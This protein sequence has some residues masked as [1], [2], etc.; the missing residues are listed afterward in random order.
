MIHSV[1]VHT[2]AVCSRWIAG[3]A[4]SSRQVSVT[5]SNA[6]ATPASAAGPLV[7]Q[8]KSSVPVHTDGVCADTGPV[9]NGIGIDRHSSTAG[10]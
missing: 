7:V 10:S 8:T 4:D 3:G 5:G 6:V 1:P 9:G 2:D